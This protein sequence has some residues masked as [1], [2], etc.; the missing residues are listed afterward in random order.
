M[1]ASNAIAAEAFR[2]DLLGALP[3]LRAFAVSLTANQAAADDL[4]QET[5]LKAWK[6]QWRFRPGT[7]LKAWSCTILRNQ[8]YSELRK[9]KREV[10]DA[11]GTMAGQ[12]VAPAAQEA[13]SDL[14]RVRQNFSRLPVSMREAL[15]LVG[16]Q[17]LSYE[18]AAELFG[19][20]VGTVKSRVS[21]ARNLMASSLGLNS[22]H[23]VV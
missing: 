1:G 23:A 19:C 4:I 16:A 15:L 5:L 9:R 12:M 14:D 2:A 3:D 21:R 10:E 22:R 13:A 6:H 20:Q 11:D 8:F 7:N 18:D 17:G